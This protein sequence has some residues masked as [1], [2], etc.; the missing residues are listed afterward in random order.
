[1]KGPK[2]SLKK[3]QTLDPKK[4]VYLED[5]NLLMP[6]RSGSKKHLNMSSYYSHSILV[7]DSGVETARNKEGLP[8]GSNQSQNAKFHSLLNNF[9]F[10]KSLQ[11]NIEDGN[12]SKYLLNEI[13]EEG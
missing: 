5:N 13:I 1:L 3:R 11:Q 6:I 9:D 12:I 8:K 2:Q 10:S 7:D 4:T